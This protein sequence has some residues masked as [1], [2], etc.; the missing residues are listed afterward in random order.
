MTSKKNKARSAKDT[1]RKFK[2]KANP[3]AADKIEYI[4]YKD[5]QHVAALHV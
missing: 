2:K 1:S 5:S 4:D 3:L